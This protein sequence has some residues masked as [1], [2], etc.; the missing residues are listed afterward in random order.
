MASSIVC[1]IDSLKKLSANISGRLCR[2]HIELI[3]FDPLLEELNVLYSI[4][5]AI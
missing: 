3:D 1:M 5:Q 4:T 2:E